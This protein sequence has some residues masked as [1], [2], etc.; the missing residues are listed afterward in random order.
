MHFNE[1]GLITNGDFGCR[2]GL[3]Q[4]IGTLKSENSM[5]L[6]AVNQREHLK[7]TGLAV[8]WARVSFGSVCKFGS[9][10]TPFCWWISRPLYTQHHFR[11]D[12]RQTNPPMKMEVALLACAYIP[13][14]IHMHGGGLLNY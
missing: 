10:S 9:T 2:G 6:N 14:L 13:D 4:R 8:L 12:F 5:L 7:K 11:L 1:H 3:R